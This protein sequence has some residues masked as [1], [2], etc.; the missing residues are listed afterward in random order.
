MKKWQNEGPADRALRVI[1]GIAAI[2]IAARTTGTTSNVWF[3][4]G[5]IALVTAALG[6]CLP[7]KLFGISTLKKGKR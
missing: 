5:I 3:V 2:V 6:F 4:I 7:Y 1:I